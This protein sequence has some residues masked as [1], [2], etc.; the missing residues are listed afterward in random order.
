MIVAGT[1]HRPDKLGGYTDGAFT[2]LAG[3]AMTE[4]AKLEGV[5]A[6]ISGMAL[7]WDMALAVAAINAK[8][9]LIAALPF[10]DQAKMWPP[11][12]RQLHMAILKQA[13]RVEICSP[14]D[15]QIYKMQ[16]R[17][18]WMVDECTLLLALW[19]GTSGGTRN[20]ILYAEEKR[21]STK[22]IWSEWTK[23]GVVT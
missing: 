2:T 1:G 7:G 10:A 17:N 22:N 13:Q 4:L 15:Y 8:I 5:S 20:C 9:P 19:N 6:V 12:N 23:L 21:R 18:R 3:F 14:G 16:R 11:E